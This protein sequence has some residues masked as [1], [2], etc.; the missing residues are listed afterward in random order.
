MD[1]SFTYTLETGEVTVPQIG[2]S[3]GS[4]VTGE[5]TVTEMTRDEILEAGIDV[6]DPDNGHVFKYE[7]TL[8]F[9][10]GLEI[11]T[12]PSVIFKNNK[13]ESIKS[14]FGDQSNTGNVFV[15]DAPEKITIT[16]VSENLYIVV[17]GQTKWLKEMFHVQLLV[18]NTSLTDKLIDC[19]ADLQLPNGLSLADLSTGEQSSQQTIDSVDCGQSQSLDWYIRGDKTGDY[20]ISAS[21]KGKFSNFQ[22]P[23]EYTFK[24]QDPLHVY[25]GTDM[26][27][28]VHCSDAAY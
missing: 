20:D 4:V 11:Y 12:I 17:Q 25:A 15:I 3:T 19:T 22:D 13:G 16:K 26:H 5:L 10:D 24:T 2:I 7:V 18:V 27:L 14:Y 28:T 23:F 9:S 8:K 6:N 1:R 21:L